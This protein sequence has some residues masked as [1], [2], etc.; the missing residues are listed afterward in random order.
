V[1]G[2]LTVAGSAQ[3]QLAANHPA[4]QGHFPGNPI[5]PGA[6]LLDEVLRAV[7]TGE[8]QSLSGCEIRSAKFLRPVR[9]GDQLLI[10]WTDLAGEEK[11][12]ECL[13]GEHPVVTGILKLANP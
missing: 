7:A 12:F 3:R 11:K 9:P 10:R 1:R 5:I 4:A 8:G 2:T 6:V 13:V